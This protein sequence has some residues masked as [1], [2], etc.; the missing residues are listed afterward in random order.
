MSLL[1]M[2]TKREKNLKPSAGLFTPFKLGQMRKADDLSETLSAKRQSLIFLNLVEGLQV[3][4]YLH[5][6]CNT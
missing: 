6:F 5:S 3:T 2:I 4:G 1:G